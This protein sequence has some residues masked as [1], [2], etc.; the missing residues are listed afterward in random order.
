LNLKAFHYE[1]LADPKWKGKVCIRSGQHPYN[2]ALISAMLIHNG[3][4]ATE[5]WLRGVKANLARS[6]TGG[7][8]DVARDILGN[9]CEIGL[10]N[11]YYAA[12]MKTARPGSDQRKWGDAIS[13]IRPS[14]EKTGATF[15]NI[16]GAG[17]ARYSPNL[18]HAITLMDFLASEEGQ[19]LY[20][21]ADFEYP[22]RQNIAV[23]PMLASFGSLTMDTLTLKEIAAQRK[24]ASALVDRVKFDQ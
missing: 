8:R 5:K 12:Q 6:P 19:S 10:A 17:V 16:S 18:K 24:K 9:I 2:I 13:V 3:E 23:D 22:V 4:Q 11:A 7:D 1:D 14:F 15:V 20:A 21:S